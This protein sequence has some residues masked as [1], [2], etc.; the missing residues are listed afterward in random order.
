ML[1]PPLGFELA[2]DPIKWV[3][4]HCISN[5]CAYNLAAHDGSQAGLAHQ[6]LQRAAGYIDSLTAQ[7]A[8]DLVSPR[9]LQICLQYPFAISM[10]STSSRWARAQRKAGRCCT[11][12]R[13]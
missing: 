10:V 3:R 13:H 9:D 6:T 1:I 11:T 5:R 7:L 2:M 4:C 12:Y 8:P